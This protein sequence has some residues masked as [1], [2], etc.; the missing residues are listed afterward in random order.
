VPPDRR[1]D[2]LGG[3]GGQAAAEFGWR[4]IDIAKYI[5]E[6]VKEFLVAGVSFP[7]RAVAIAC[8]APNRVSASL[9]VAHRFTS[10]IF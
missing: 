6:A 1:R 10:L 9:H 4:A 3:G 8:S 5:R 7:V 2:P